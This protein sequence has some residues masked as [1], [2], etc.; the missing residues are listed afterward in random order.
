[1]KISVD[2]IEPAPAPITQGQVLG[3]LVVSAID[4][5]DIRVPLL[6]GASVARLGMFGR[7]GAAFNYLA[8]GA[9]GQ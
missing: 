3:T 5:P 2:I 6:A 9:A 7:L 4:M 1:M 8:W